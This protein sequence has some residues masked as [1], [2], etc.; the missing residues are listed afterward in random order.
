M[1]EKLEK[2]CMCLYANWKRFF[3]LGVFNLI[4]HL[5]VHLSY[6]AKVGGPLKYRWMYHI[7]RPSHILKMVANKARLEGYITKSFY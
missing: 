2:R 3:P 6:D 1:M 5:L 7:E 4:Q